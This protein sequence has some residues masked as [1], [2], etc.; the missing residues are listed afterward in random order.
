MKVTQENS[1][2]FDDDLTLDIDNENSMD[3]FDL[4]TGNESTIDTLKTIILSID[5]EITDDILQQ[6]EE[7]L[8]D[9]T[10]VWSDDK[11]RQVYIQGLSKIGKYIYQHKTNAHP[12]SIKLLIS[13]YHNLE[14]IV[15][16]DPPMSSENQKELLLIDVK[17]F[18]TLKVQI[19]AQNDQVDDSGVAPVEASMSSEDAVDEL[20]FLKAQILGIDWEV[21][22]KELQKINK[23]VLRLE[24]VFIQSKAKRILLQG[25]GALSSY[26]N[27]KKSQSNN[28]AFSLLRSFYELLE[29]ICCKELTTEEEEKHLLLEVEKFQQFKSDISNDQE[30]LSNTDE[31]DTFDTTN[32]Q[33]DE[34]DAKVALD[35][36]ARLASVFGDFDESNQH[37]EED[38]ALAGV[39]VETAADDDT[40]EDAL[41]YADG[42]I[43]PALSDVDDESSFSVEKIAG[44]L[45]QSTTPA[46]QVEP[47]VGDEFVA[48]GV[49]VETEA[50]D[51]SEED[52]LPLIDGEIAPALSGSEDDRQL[53]ELDSI[54][55]GE[56]SNSDDLD[57]RLDS[58][59]DDVS[60]AE[61]VVKD[62]Q[63]DVV[64]ALDAED[65]ATDDSLAI[66]DEQLLAPDVEEPQEEIEREIDY[67]YEEIAPALAF[68]N[69]DEEIDLSELSETQDESIQK[70]FEETI[71]EDIELNL[72]ETVSF[73]T[74]PSVEV[75][76]GDT[77]PV[78]KD[79]V[80]LEDENINTPEISFSET[81]EK[82]NEEIV[83]EVVE[84]DVEV[85]LLPGEEYVD[86]LSIDAL[87]M[88]IASLEKT[89]STIDYIGIK[90]AID[91]LQENLT[92]ETVQSYFYEI[93]RLRSFSEIDSTNKT[94]LQLLSTAGQHL[95]K[96]ILEPNPAVLL[97]INEIYSALEG[98]IES[99][100]EQTSQQLYSCTSQ[101]LF[102]LQEENKIA[103]EKS[104][105]S[106][107][108]IQQKI[109]EPVTELAMVDDVNLQSY[110]DNEIQKIR[111]YVDAEIAQFR[112]E[113]S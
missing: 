26:I 98:S 68:N 52:A 111:Q 61:Q 24:D 71:E 88:E 37:A 6:L 41:P 20:Q 50:D 57:T 9:L 47:V 81:S 19:I 14:S 58:F 54:A 13:L 11:I 66:L 77:D 51:E 27:K 79:L 23:E 55:D 35:V 70:D 78:D 12:D 10:D 56:Q 5:W 75:E 94:F 107:S 90:V 101:V 33:S 72:Q 16:S 4:S 105:K 7:E 84:D 100:F 102:L 106:D 30:S 104:D 34:D 89:V 44:D 73:D 80:S 22:G 69:Q 113:R 2:H 62:N 49:A 38:I 63:T 82:K 74:S 46:V 53:D 15:L 92:K 67:E 40:D 39:H 108:D 103:S 18:D 48:Q 28:D 64:P 76:E 42:A 86:E 87:D 17:K 45:A 65:I 85:D 110:I 43:A 91:G 97:L 95:E 36:E 93:N 59:F 109:E 29:K 60:P 99:S 31:Q 25:I 96:N 3:L 8:V 21:E 83:F 32:E 112:K 1:K